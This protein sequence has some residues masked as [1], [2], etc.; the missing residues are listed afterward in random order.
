MMKGL[1][2]YALVGTVVAALAGPAATAGAAPAVP[3]GVPSAFTLSLAPETAANLDAALHEEAFDWTSATLFAEQADREGAASAAAV[4]RQVATTERSDHV[5]RLAGLAGVV[6]TDAQNL[7]AAIDGETYEATSMYPQFAAQARA[8]GC[9]EVANRFDRIASEEWMHAQKYRAALA[10]L[11]SS[12]PSFPRPGSYNPVT[13]L[14]GPAACSAAQTQ[15]NLGTAM[16]GESLATAKYQLFADAARA[17]GNAR[18]ADLFTGT[19]QVEFREHMSNE[20]ILVGLVQDT[21]ANLA[22]AAARADAQ[23]RTEYPAD[24][25]AAYAAGDAAVGD[26]FTDI[27]A[28]EA[29]QRDALTR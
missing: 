22:A 3:A 26:A 20:A 15:A 8:D 29:A 5:V 4:L 7:Q 27:A 24:A 6:G 12:R 18:L 9:G 2:A 28:A 25:A 21:A 14:P 11:S 16:R 13:V 19:A 10:A 1:R 17:G 23:A